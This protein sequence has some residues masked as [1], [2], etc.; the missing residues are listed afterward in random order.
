[1]TITKVYTKK[2]IEKLYASLS[3][4][5]EIKKTPPYA[6]F[7]IKM[8]D[9]SITAYAS[10]KVLFQ[11]EGAAFYASIQKEAQ[12]R[13]TPIAQYPQAGSDEVGTGDYFGPVVVCATYIEEKNL[14]FLRELH[15]QDSKQICDNDILRIA[16]QL[17]NTIPYSI[18]ILQNEKYNQIHPTNNMNQ[19]KAKLHNQSFLNLQTKYKLQLDTIYVDQFTS[20]SSYFKYLQNE[21]KVIRNIHFETKAEDKYSSVACASIIARYHFLQTLD[22]MEQHFG[23]TFPKGAGKNVDIAAKIF[24][25]TFGETALKKVCKLHFANTHKMK[26]L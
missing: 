18:L 7:Q 24:F 6:L 13:P 15:I 9:C 11:G 25:D 10:L 3:K 4:K 21:K 22:K 19:I 16:P 8:S 2:Q 5:G 26:L 1:M 12:V 17:I 23:F 20:P 14:S